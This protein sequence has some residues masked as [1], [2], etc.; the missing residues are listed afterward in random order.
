MTVADVLSDFG[1]R[2]N[3]SL[4]IFTVAL[5]L[6]RILP[7]VILSP[8][9]GGDAVPNEAKIGLGVLLAAVLFPSVSDRVSSI[10]TQALPYIGLLLKEMFVG[11]ALAFVAALV[12]DAARVA[13]SIVDT[14]SGAMMA[15]VMVPQIQQQVTLYASL[16]V[17]LAIVLF[18]TLDGHHV[19]IEALAESFITVPPDQFPKFSNGVWAFFDLILRTFGDMMIVGIALAAP[20]FLAT[21]LTDLSLGLMNRVAPQ[22]QVFFISMSIKPMV[23]ALVTFLS[24]ALVMERFQLEFAHMLRLFQKAIHLLA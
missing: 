13:G 16:K 11:V 20:A 12:F 5:L 17:Q 8:V 3:L 7:V 24:I 10:P 15:Q 2:T 6:A 14:M 21:F 4:V 22:V 18:L 19:I 9:L 23:V 1:A